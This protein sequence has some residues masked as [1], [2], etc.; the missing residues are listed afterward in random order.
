MPLLGPLGILGM[1]GAAGMKPTGCRV[2]GDEDYTVGEGSLQ[3]AES[4]CNK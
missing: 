3:G 2:G 1:R 4:A